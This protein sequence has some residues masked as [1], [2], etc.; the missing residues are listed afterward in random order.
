[1]CFVYIDDLIVYSPSQQQHL[2]DLEVVFQKLKEA[3]L[4]FVKICLLGIYIQLFSMQKY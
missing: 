1:M 4:F 2:K 3:N